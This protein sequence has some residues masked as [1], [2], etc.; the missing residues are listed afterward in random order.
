VVRP[1][2]LVAVVV[3]V[4]GLGPSLLRW[5]LERGLMPHLSRLLARG[6]VYAARPPL[7]YTPPAWATALTGVGPGWHGVADFLRPSPGGPMRSRDYPLTAY[8]TL[9]PFSWRLM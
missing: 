9:S 5:A 2:R 4:D 6:A 3:G 8:L 1:P 7:P